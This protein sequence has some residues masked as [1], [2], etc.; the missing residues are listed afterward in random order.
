VTAPNR[1]GMGKVAAHAAT[2]A[3]PVNIGKAQVMT[4]T[5]TVGGVTLAKTQLI[6]QRLAKGPRQ[7]LIT[8]V[9][10]LKGASGTSPWFAPWNGNPADDPTPGEWGAPELP[11]PGYGLRVELRWG[12]GGASAR[13]QFDYPAAGLVFGVTA[14]MLDLVVVPVDDDEPKV[15]ASLDLVPAVGAWMVEGQAAD[16]SPL[17]WAEAPLSLDA[18][19]QVNYSV[20]P[21]ARNLEVV[22]NGGDYDAPALTV[23]WFD[24][25]DAAVKREFI[26]QDL[27]YPGQSSGFGAAR[28]LLKVP[29]AAT[30]V[31]I[32]NNNTADGLLLATW[33]I[34]LV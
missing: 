10:M 24:T 29:S 15:Y 16:P 27:R 4:T 17:Q 1:T 23:T 2:L 11:D 26:A 33:E 28:A 9:P 30:Y 6:S 7:L 13:T 19:G 34:G 32:K 20:K 22:F 3:A 14:D 12:A 8:L 5:P 25:N 31:Q 21:F 18:A